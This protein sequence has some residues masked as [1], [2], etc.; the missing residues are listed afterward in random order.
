MT[1]MTE[2]ISEMEF[3][4]ELTKYPLVR[5]KN[6]INVRFDQPDQQPETKPLLKVD[7]VKVKKE[8]SS[9]VDQDAPE[10]SQ[11]RTGDFWTELRE[12]IRTS[13]VKVDPDAFLQAFKTQHESF[14]KDLSKDDIKFCLANWGSP[15]SSSS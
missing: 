8:S 10:T 5:N 2:G 1:T 12:A 4:Q 6:Y 3:L 13:G 9:M 14:L 11:K 15:S 7:P